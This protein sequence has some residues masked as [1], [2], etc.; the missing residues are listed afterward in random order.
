MLSFVAA[1]CLSPFCC[2]QTSEASALVLK[3]HYPVYGM[4]LRPGGKQV[5]VASYDLEVYD[6]E[7]GK[8][9]FHSASSGRRIVYSHDG[10]W[11]ATVQVMM[12][13]LDT[14]G[15]V[16]VWDADTF[17]QKHRVGGIEAFFAPDSKKLIT[18]SGYAHF[19]KA[20]PPTYAFLDLASG[21]AT[22]SELSLDPA[23]RG[24]WH[25]DR[26]G[27]LLE[28]DMDGKLLFQRI[29]SQKQPEALVAAC[30]AETGKLVAIPKDV[31]TRPIFQ[32]HVSADG[33][34]YLQGSRVRPI[35]RQTRSNKE[36]C[37]L[38]A[39]PDS[40]GS[41]GGQLHQFSPD[42]TKIF[43]L[44][45][46]RRGPN[47]LLVWDSQTGKLEPNAHEFKAKI[48]H[49]GLLRKGQ[50]EL[51]MF[52]ADE[53]GVVQIIDPKASKVIRRLREGGHRDGV[54]CVDFSPDGKLIASGDRDGHVLLWDAR[55]GKQ[56]REFETHERNWCL[57]FRPKSNELGGGGFKGVAIWDVSSGKIVRRLGD[58]FFQKIAFAPDGEL[59]AA[60]APRIGVSVWS[61]ADNKLLRVLPGKELRIEDLCFSPDGQALATCGSDG[62]VH[63]W[64]PRTGETVRSFESEIQKK[65]KRPRRL[66]R[67]AFFPDGSKIIAEDDIGVLTCWETATGRELF[68]Y[69]Q[70]RGR[71]ALALCPDGKRLAYGSSSG[72]VVE[73]DVETGKL[74][75]T[76]KGH[77]Q[78]V[79][80]LAYDAA[81]N[82]LATASW[83]GDI[84][85]WSVAP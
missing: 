2:G 85:I 79:P 42:S 9:V 3:G 64:N 11:L 20:K 4:A 40:E 60:S 32:T 48:S 82:R 67:L 30:S 52:A 25:G 21:K 80:S 24:L 36:V 49:L 83:D 63:L 31:K 65:T 8:L 28:M 62:L 44:T 70:G 56:L 1:F 7:T 50:D 46:E 34:R 59:L 14:H 18:I 6:L 22:A 78:T 27:R 69:Q 26:E 54:H 15:T 5:A 51:L 12:G 41:R 71:S 58:D 72:L 68:W 75:R 33:S 37:T 77:R 17:E 23:F 19:Q 84:R 66:E 81:G 10:K 13:M 39:P 16:T 47:K 53:R 55:D 61:L 73:R 45:H 76:L 29:W 57:K 35:V 43:G 74:V 38:E